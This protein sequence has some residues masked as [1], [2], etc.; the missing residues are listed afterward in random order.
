MQSSGNARLNFDLSLPT[1]RDKLMA[2]WSILQDKFTA[3][4]TN[5]R[6]LHKSILKHFIKAIWKL[7][8]IIMDTY[9]SYTSP[10]Y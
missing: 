10:V 1:G 4:I 7:N 3:E 6:K 9:N 8:V 5:T 2:H